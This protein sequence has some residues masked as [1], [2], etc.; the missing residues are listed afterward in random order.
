VFGEIQL[1]GKGIR[2]FVVGGE[3]R[4]R[5]DEMLKHMLSTVAETSYHSSHVVVSIIV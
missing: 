4:E 5:R 1:T 2:C 3:L